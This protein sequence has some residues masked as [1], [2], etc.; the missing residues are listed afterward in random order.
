MN[1]SGQYLQDMIDGM[2]AR[3]QKERSA[4]QMTL[5]ELIERLEAMP[6]LSMI[7]KLESPHSY[8]GYYSDLAFERGEEKMMVTELLVIAKE[9]MGKEFVGYKGGEFLM[10]QSTPVWISN[11]GTASGVKLMEI[12]DDGTIITV[13]EV[14]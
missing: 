12:V 1:L 9:C 4:S 13:D 8:R 10:G 6:P 11:Y 2:S 7:D 14:Y 5:G 3:L